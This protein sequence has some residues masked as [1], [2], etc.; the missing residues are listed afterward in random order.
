VSA[1][2]VVAAPSTR[3]C[4]G[5]SG[6]RT[7]PGEDDPAPE[8]SSAPGRPEAGPG[9]YLRDVMYGALDGVITTLAVVAGTTG[10]DLEPRIGIILG[11]ANLVA[12]GLSMGA[13]NYL[14]LKSELEQTGRSVAVEM[15]WRH[16]VATA[17]AFAV[18]GSVPLIAYALPHSAWLSAFTMALVLSAATLGLVGGLRGRYI[19]K[20]AWRSAAEVLV[21]GAAAAGA[22]YF[23][24]ALVER[25]IS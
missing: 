14:G 20:S 18:V 15:P 9:H 11:I 2:A 8:V 24:G 3:C 22:A 1:G 19:G 4:R 7:T 5:A 12:D 21:I 6:L 16:G 17:T 10:A 23:I 25:W 13:S